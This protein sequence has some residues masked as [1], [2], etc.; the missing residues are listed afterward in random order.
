LN[1]LSRACCTFDGLIKSAPPSFSVGKLNN[2]GLPLVERFFTLIS[3]LC[4]PVI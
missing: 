4:R 2:K 3:A 1:I